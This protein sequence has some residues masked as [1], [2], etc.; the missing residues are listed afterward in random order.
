MQD[1]GNLNGVVVLRVEGSS[2]MIFPSEGGLVRAYDPLCEL[3]LLWPQQSLF[4]GH[5][6]ATLLCNPSGG[7]EVRGM[8]GEWGHASE[9]IRVFTTDN[10]EVLGEGDGDRSGFV[11]HLLVDVG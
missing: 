9:G 6:I 10:S 7:G 2:L 3:D 1:N 11:S 5:L 8:R 4:Y